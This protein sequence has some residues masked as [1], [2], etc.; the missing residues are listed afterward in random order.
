MKNIVCLFSGL[1]FALLS[2]KNNDSLNEPAPVPTGKYELVWE[3]NFDGAGKPDASKWS[4]EIGFIRNEELQYFTNSLKNVRQEN[5]NLI[6]E[7]HKEQISNQNFVSED[8]ASWISNREFGKY[9]SGSI[10]TEG[11]VSWQYGKIEVRAK[12]PK[13]VGQWPAIWMLG[14][15]LRSVYWPKCGEIDIM[16]HVGFTKDTIYGTVHTE[17]YNHTKGT[18]VGKGIFIADPYEEFHTYSIEWDAEKI[19]FLLDDKVYHEFVNE[20]KTVDEWPF[21]QPFHLK[22]NVSVGGSW[23]GAQGIDD[24]VFPQKMVIDYVHVYQKN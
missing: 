22:L 16:E 23:G 24:S 15:N 8:D 4:Y 1:V 13:G 21:D 6:I 17:T 3:E 19:Q 10:S 5:G 20:Q 2:C 14:E 7:G 18:G 9:T 11:L 12:L